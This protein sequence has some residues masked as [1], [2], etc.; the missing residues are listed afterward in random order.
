M[1]T[2]PTVASLRSLLATR[3]PAQVRSPVGVLPTRI[4]ALD[5]AL[6]GG[7]ATGR[8]T[9]IVSSVPGTGGQ[10]IVAQLLKAT[11]KARQRLALVDGA[12][13]FAP[14]S[15][16]PDHLRHLVWVRSRCV[17]D[18]MACADIL[19]RDGN[20]A[21]VALDTR[22]LSERAL[23]KT[24][25]TAWHRLRHAA[26]AGSIAVVVLSTTGIVPAVPWRLVLHDPLPR[27]ARRSRRD[28][29]ADGLHVEVERG[30]ETEETKSA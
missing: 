23:L 9:E 28:E 3:F 21:V 27:E 14:A 8:F 4:D 20:Y 30:R 18:V 12:D 13:A 7:L 25:A 15:V 22:G 6:G 19:L 1:P 26:E 10:T 11:R 5:A 2:S 16:P 29:L 24:P 17:A